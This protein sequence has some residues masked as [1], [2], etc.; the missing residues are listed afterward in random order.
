[1]WLG[2]S[3]PTFYW[4]ATM[5]FGPAL[6]LNAYARSAVA[7]SS[8]SKRTLQVIDYVK[9]IIIQLPSRDVILKYN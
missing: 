3:V 2:G 9:R 6:S 8:I 4:D 5:V 1:M 7:D